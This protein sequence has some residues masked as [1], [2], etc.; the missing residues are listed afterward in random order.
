MGTWKIAAAA[1]VLLLPAAVADVA[2]RCGSRP[3]RNATVVRAPFESCAFVN[4]RTEVVCAPA[5]ACVATGAPGSSVCTRAC[6]TDADCATLGADAR[7][8][9]KGRVG[10][11]TSEVA[12]CA[13]GGDAAPP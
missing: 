9:G 3:R 5:L 11:S 12:V 4:P 13:R 8:S 6:T 10:A 7:C 1:A 2:P